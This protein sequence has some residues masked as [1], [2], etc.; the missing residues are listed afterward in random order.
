MPQSTCEA[1][2]RGRSFTAGLAATSRS[3]R[4]TGG[5]RLRYEALLRKFA[6]PSQGGVEEIR[7]ALAV[8]DV[9]TAARAAHSLKGSAANLGATTLAE[10]AAKVEL[11]VTS[12][13][14][15]T[16]TLDALTSSFEKVVQAIRSALPVERAAPIDADGSS[17]PGI[18][19]QPL[20]R[21]RTLLKHDDGEVADFILEARPVLSKVLTETEMTTL[22]DSIG[23]FDFEAALNSL[24][25]IAA[26]LSLTLE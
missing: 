19:V 23:N 22:T 3:S 4:R 8:G 18:V 2:R 9:P 14:D 6:Q 16:E 20:T 26:R 1:K 21:L 11:A 25:S 15:V 24:S 13:K 12:R 10:D 7:T 5:N 17:D